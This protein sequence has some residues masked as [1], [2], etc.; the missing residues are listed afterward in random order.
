MFWGWPED[1]QKQM[2]TKCTGMSQ[3]ARGGGGGGNAKP[4]YT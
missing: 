4:P 3:G 1:K 2:Y